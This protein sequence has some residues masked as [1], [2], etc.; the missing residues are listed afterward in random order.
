MNFECVQNLLRAFE[1]ELSFH[2]GIINM[3]F[4]TSGS[5]MINNFFT[6][7]ISRIDLLFFQSTFS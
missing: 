7:I 3:N 1:V 5:F 6:F 2:G 4:D